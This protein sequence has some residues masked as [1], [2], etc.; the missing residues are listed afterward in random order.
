MC[1]VCVCVC[2]C[3]LHILSWV[4][5]SGEV[6]SLIALWGVACLLLCVAFYLCHFPPLACW[7]PLKPV[8]LVNEVEDPGGML[9]IVCRW[10]CATHTG[11]E[12]CHCMWRF[13]WMALTSFWW[14]CVLVVDFGGLPVVSQNF[15]EN[16]CPWGTGW[17]YCGCVS[18]HVPS[19]LASGS[20]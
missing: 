2:D 8:Q 17:W 10:C 20:Q 14:C 6:L 18:W 3:R 13:G 1:S 19:S 15:I 12:L 4:W 5:L 11:S 16:G 7:K 9:V